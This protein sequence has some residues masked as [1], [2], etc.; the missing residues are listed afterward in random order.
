MRYENKIFENQTVTLDNNEFVGCTF[1]GCS[2]HY[3]SGA[4]TI[5]N[6]KIDE[7]ELRLH[8]AAQT[9]ADLQLQFMSN[10]ASK[11][12]AGGKLEIGGRTFVLTETD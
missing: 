8:G 12:H 5:E 7:S 1:K 10:I 4:T 2:L 9:G 6:T 3:T 11:L